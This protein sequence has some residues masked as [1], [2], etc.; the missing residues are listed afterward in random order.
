MTF[1]LE[2]QNITQCKPSLSRYMT[3]FQALITTGVR[4]EKKYCNEYRVY[5]N[6]RSPGVKHFVL[7]ITYLCLNIRTRVSLMNTRYTELFTF[8]IIKYV[9]IN[10]HL[11]AGCYRPWDSLFVTA[12]FQSVV[13]GLS[14]V[15][16]QL[17]FLVH[18]FT[19]RSYAFGCIFCSFK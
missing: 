16:D 2:I 13:W 11:R 9:S 7:G 4:L 12:V 8:I 19:T 5:S 6:H 14:A 15:P 10:R 1:H 17:M 18:D 3:I